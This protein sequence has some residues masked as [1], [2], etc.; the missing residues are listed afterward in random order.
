MVVCALIVSLGASPVFAAPKQQ[1]VTVHKGNFHFVIDNKVYH[2][3]TENQAF[4]YNNRTYVPIR[5][6]SYLLEKWVDWNASTATVSVKMPTEAQLSQLK[7]YK[8][9][10]LMPNVDFNTP[11]AK[12]QVLKMLVTLD[13]ANY[14]F[15]G[16]AQVVP[17]DVTTIM[18]NGT[19][20][21]PIRFFAELIQ[22]DITYQA[23]SH[24]VVMNPRS[25]GEQGNSGTGNGSN[26]PGETPGEATG[27]EIKP[28]RE[29]LVS[30][31][32]S[33]LQALESTC[34]T[35]VYSLYDKYSKSKDAEERA[36]YIT[37]GLTLLESCDTQVEELLSELDANLA[38]Y[39]YDIGSDSSNYRDTY[40][41]KK[42]A[43]YAKFA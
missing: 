23:K 14:N 39:E 40:K 36:G 27:E 2:T 13:V 26:N 24:A 9:K 4:L 21:V 1:E 28:S 33:K 42:D 11:T 10:Y 30:T 18:H 37:Q 38:K 15:F 32:N 8:N 25:N 20:Y 41:K 3:P 19:I 43:L 5:F 35:R 16:K 6:A 7:N 29:S 12:L 22:H 31:T 34:V 17:S